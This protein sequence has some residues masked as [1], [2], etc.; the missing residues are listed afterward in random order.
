[1]W[2]ASKIA[3]AAFEPRG[4]APHLGVLALLAGLSAGACAHGGGGAEGE[5]QSEPAATTAPVTPPVERPRPA[6]P[7]PPE[8]APILVE[9]EPEQPNE[10]QD[11]RSLVEASRAARARRLEDSV[12]NRNRRPIAVINDQNLGE[13]AE[14]GELTYAAE[15]E[16]PPTA[17]AGETLES[18]GV[19]QY[20][21]D[22]AS[23]LRE[24]WRRAVE[25]RQ[26][27][28][29][30]AALL[31]RRFYAEDD[32]FVRDGQIKPEWDQALERLADLRQEEQALRLELDELYAEG[33]L[34]GADPRWLDDGEEGLEAPGE[35]AVERSP[36]AVNELEAH[37]VQNPPN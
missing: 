37:E 8:P 31:R 15:E 5:P 13:F 1:M 7:P 20:W 16:V 32:P 26:D 9:I 29:D 11:H 25:E 10:E 27:V 3:M 35:V 30:R 28:E 33:A 36:E 18:P 23:E 21:R 17:E 6:P 2:S 34:A 24:E 22:R 19:E 12:Q 4:I 14:A